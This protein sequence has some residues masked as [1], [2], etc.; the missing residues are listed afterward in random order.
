MFLF[1]ALFFLLVGLFVPTIR[2][3]YLSFR[4][5]RGE[6]FAGIT[7]YRSI[8]RDKEM[9]SFDGFFDIFTS[10]L[11]LLAV[12]VALAGVGWAVLH[13]RRTGAGTD[14]SALDAGAL[15]LRH[16]RP[17]RARHGERAPR[18]SCGTTSSGS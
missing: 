17:R 9:I 1:P 3:I 6:E 2:T 13:G 7:N 14:L 5:R 18:A 15:A 8:F 4:S 10:R 12:I 11:F 16:R